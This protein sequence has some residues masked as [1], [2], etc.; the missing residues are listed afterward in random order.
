MTTRFPN[1]QG[2]FVEFRLTVT[3][4]LLWTSVM[5]FIPQ[6]DDVL[7]YGLSGDS[8]TTYSVLSVRYEFREPIPEV[9]DPPIT[10]DVTH[11]SHMAIAVVKVGT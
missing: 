1:E 3:D 6:A 11:C 9:G 7:Q 10:L 5:L 4:E 8:L 2:A